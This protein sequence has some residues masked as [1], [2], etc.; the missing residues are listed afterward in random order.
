[1]TGQGRE[2][3]SSR[4]CG[5]VSLGSSLVFGILAMSNVVLV[6]ML[7]VT[8]LGPLFFLDR[9]KMRSRMFVIMSAV[10]AGVAGTAVAYTCR[11]RG[12]RFP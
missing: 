3:V 2:P 11:S 9:Y 5:I 7:A 4:F 8:A 10:A 1:M 12:I 6:T